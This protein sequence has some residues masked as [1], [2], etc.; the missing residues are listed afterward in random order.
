MGPILGSGQSREGGNKRQGHELSLVRK[1][2]RM[3]NSSCYGQDTHFNFGVVL[4]S[5][6]HQLFIT[7][8]TWRLIENND[9][10]EEKEEFM[11]ITEERITMVCR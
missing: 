3:G 5:L 10:H 4:N 1:K 7:G 6:A 8:V 11:E 9:D 2:A